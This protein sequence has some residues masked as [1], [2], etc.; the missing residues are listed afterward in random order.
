MVAFR[1]SWNQSVCLEPEQCTVSAKQEPA[2]APLVGEDA[3]E[4]PLEAPSI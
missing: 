3:P 1:R 2:A 4:G